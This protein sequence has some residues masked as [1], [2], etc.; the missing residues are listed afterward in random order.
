MVMLYCRLICGGYFS[1]KKWIVPIAL[2]FVLLN[3]LA[4]FE[5]VGSKAAMAKGDLISTVKNLMG[6]SVPLYP[7]YRPHNNTQNSGDQNSLFTVPVFSNLQKPISPQ[8]NS[9][10]SIVNNARYLRSDINAGQKSQAPPG[11]GWFVLFVLLY[12]ISLNRSNLPAV[13][14]LLR[15]RLSPNCDVTQLG[16]FIGELC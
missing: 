10:F 12:I 13:I 2:I 8:D 3:S 14:A 9:I 5:G 11:C 4:F 7:E 16:F 6:A 1:V 15:G